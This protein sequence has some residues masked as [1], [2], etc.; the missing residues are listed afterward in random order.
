MLFAAAG[1]GEIQKTAVLYF[2]EIHVIDIKVDFFGD[3]YLER[4]VAKAGD[5]AFHLLFS[6][7]RL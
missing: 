4:I 5:Y 3:F 1:A 2:I 7:R 6:S